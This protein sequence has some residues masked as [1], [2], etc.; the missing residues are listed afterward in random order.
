[1]ELGRNYKAEKQGTGK[2]ERI[3]KRTMVK[4]HRIEKH[5]TGSRRLKKSYEG[6]GNKDQREPEDR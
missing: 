1:M 4:D 2:D 6:V 3:V 5:C